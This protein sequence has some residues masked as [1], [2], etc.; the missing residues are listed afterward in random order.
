MVLDRL[1]YLTPYKEDQSSDD[2]QIMRNADETG[3][4]DVVLAAVHREVAFV[5][6]GRSLVV[7]LSQGTTSPAVL[8]CV[9]YYSAIHHSSALSS[10]REQSA[11][12]L[13]S[14]LD[15][16]IDCYRPALSGW[17]CGTTIPV[18]IPWNTA[19]QLLAR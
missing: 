4:T 19:A 10:R 1:E 3:G 2:L 8:D 6:H 7:V 15:G 11:L 18:P 14:R 13:I 5:M 12:G 9:V 16:R 17:T